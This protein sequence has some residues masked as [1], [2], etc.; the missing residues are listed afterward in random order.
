MSEITEREAEILKHVHDGTHSPTELARK[1]GIS[2]PGASQALQKL[3]NKGKL[4]KRKAGRR[5]LYETASLHKDNEKF[6]LAQAL[7]S[8]A[9]VWAL[10]LSMDLSDEE[11]KRA[12]AARDIL[13]NVLARKKV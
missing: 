1:L 2:L 8:L 7:I 5:V 6:F 13:E 11:T 12:R 10:I 4:S 3:A 9:Q